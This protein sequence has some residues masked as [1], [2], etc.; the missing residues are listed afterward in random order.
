M[1]KTHECYIISMREIIN[2]IQKMTNPPISAD[3][4]LGT[5]DC[6]LKE[7]QLNFNFNKAIDYLC[8][9][10]SSLEEKKTA[11]SIQKCLCGNILCPRILA[12]N[13]VV[14]LNEPIKKYF[15]QNKIIIEPN[16]EID[17]QMLYIKLDNVVIK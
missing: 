14:N 12:N 7:E 9:T 17:I 3:K 10:A 13:R 8:G 1:A 4:I 2:P 11:D 15:E 6:I 16:E 5:L